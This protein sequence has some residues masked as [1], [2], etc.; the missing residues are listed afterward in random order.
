MGP[1]FPSPQHLHLSGTR[2]TKFASLTPIINTP[3]VDGRNLMPFTQ[4]G[5]VKIPDPLQ[6]VPQAEAQPSTYPVVI[7]SSCYHCKYYYLSTRSTS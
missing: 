7:Q 4:N 1:P 3:I 5:T 6:A 2:I